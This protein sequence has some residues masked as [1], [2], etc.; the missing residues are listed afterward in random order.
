MYRISEETKITPQLALRFIVK[1]ALSCEPM[2]RL[3]SYYIGEH[4]ILCRPKDKRA[5]NNRLVCNHA[6]Y[7]TDCTTGYFMGSPVQYR[8]RSGADISVLTDILY[9]CD[10][11]T[12]D[13]DLARNG[14]IFGRSYEMLYFS[15]DSQPVLKLASID[16]RQAFVVYDNTVEEKPIFGVYYLPQYSE[17][18]VLTGYR[19]YL[20]TRSEITE[21]YVTAAFSLGKIISSVPHYFGD[22]PLIEYYN[23]GDCQGD[24]EQVTSLIDA[25]NLLQSDR[26]NDKEQFVDAI[27]LIKGQILGDTPDEESETYRSIKEFGVMTM[28]DDGDAR[29]LTRQ[30]DENSVELLRRSLENDIHK[31]SGVPCMTDANFSGNS[32]GIAM[33]YKLL[34]FEQLTKIKERYFAEGLRLRLKMIS[35]AVFAMSAN[36]IDAEDIEIYFTHTLP[37]NEAELAE[38]VNLL[39]DIVPREQLMKLLPFV[40]EC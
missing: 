3:Y 17:N 39:K 25:Y 1:H 36:K 14:S 13:I 19:C 12:Q 32:S 28:D 30:F 37:E 22:V 38:T 26:V 7:I 15:D 5:A 2:D 24:F 10:S 6:K 35:N 23:N 27:L 31:F 21:F 9:R 18:D 20:C 33:R 29:W 4:S 8:S 16:P 11:A 40:T 34:A